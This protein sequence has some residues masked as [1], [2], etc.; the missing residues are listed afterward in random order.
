MGSGSL[1]NKLLAK[2]V[3][4]RLGRTKKR[5]A[6]SRYTLRAT[7]ACAASRAWVQARQPI[8][9]KRLAPDFFDADLRENLPMAGTASR[10]LAS[11]ELLNR[12]LFAHFDSQ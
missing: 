3:R 8:W 5:L 7:L 11:T 2:R 12:E 4:K 6:E 10:I 9:A 1:Y